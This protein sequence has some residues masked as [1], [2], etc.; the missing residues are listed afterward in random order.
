MPCL[1]TVNEI[2]QNPFPLDG[3]GWLVLYG[4]C[5]AEASIP[6]TAPPENSVGGGNL[7]GLQR[8]RQVEGHSDSPKEG[9]YLGIFADDRSRSFSSEDQSMIILEFRFQEIFNNVRKILK[10]SRISFQCEEAMEDWRS[11]LIFFFED[12]IRTVS[13][14]EALVHARDF[15]KMDHNHQKWHQGANLGVPL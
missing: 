6:P 1:G 3:F 15:E 14:R 13:Q 9:N 12:S 11:N 4:Y 2:R 8:S 10:K 7:A 5:C